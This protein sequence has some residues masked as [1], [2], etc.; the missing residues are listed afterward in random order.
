MIY[1]VTKSVRNEWRPWFAWW[2][3]RLVDGR[4]AWLH[5]IEILN[6]RHLAKRSYRVKVNIF[7]EM[8]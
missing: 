7:K 8:D 2:P 4:I 1:G 5:H 6:A 3:V